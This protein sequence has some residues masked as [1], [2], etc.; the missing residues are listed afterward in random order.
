ML[1]PFVYPVAL[2]DYPNDSLRAA[3]ERF[4]C[5]F[6]PG[7]KGRNAPAASSRSLTT[8]DC[9]EVE[10]A[11]AGQHR[12]SSVHLH[13]RHVLTDATRLGRYID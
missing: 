13:S 3:A 9:K 5:P 10:D 4:L 12:Y 8:I 6:A 2:N 11:S 1:K 7:G